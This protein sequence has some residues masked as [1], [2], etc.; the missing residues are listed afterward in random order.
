[1]R[2]ILQLVFLVLLVQGSTLART[3]VYPGHRHVFPL[4]VDGVFDDG[5][6]YATSFDV[7]NLSDG[8]THCAVWLVGLGA[9][10]LPEGSFWI[11]GHGVHTARTR[12]VREFRKGYAILECNGRVAAQATY[13]RGGGDGSTLGMALAPPAP[14]TSRIRQFVDQSRGRKAAIAIVNASYWNWRRYR[15]TLFDSAGWIRDIRILDL[16]PGGFTSRF[17]D[18]LLSVPRGFTGSLEVSGSDFHATGMLYEGGAFTTVPV[19]PLDSHYVY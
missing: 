6:H 1:M 9:G 16:P 5:T 12:G 13:R 15:L 4:V 17:V 3:D 10:R 11:H 8:W 19:V 2:R 18:E 14:A 7:S